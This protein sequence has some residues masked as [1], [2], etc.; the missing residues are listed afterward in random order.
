M[1]SSERKA[2]LQHLRNFSSRPG[3]KC[4]PRENRLAC[5]KVAPGCRHVAWFSAAKITYLCSFHGRCQ[6]FFF[7]QAVPG[8]QSHCSSGMLV[9]PCGRSDRRDKVEFRAWTDSFWF[10]HA[11]PKPS[12]V[13]W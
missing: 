9:S 2:R 5:E 8:P 1:G 12:K 13:A 6:F 10:R 11:P 7:W 3:R 4:T